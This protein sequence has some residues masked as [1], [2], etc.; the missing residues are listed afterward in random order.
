MGFWTWGFGFD[1]KEGGGRL[2]RRTRINKA[3]G[4]GGNEK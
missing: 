2:R 1:G 3:E 4:G